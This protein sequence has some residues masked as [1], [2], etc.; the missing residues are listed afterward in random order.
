M[1][2]TAVICITRT[3]YTAFLRLPDRDEDMLHRWAFYDSMSE[4]GN[5]HRVPVLFEV[6]G[7]ARFFQS[8]C[9]DASCLPFQE[10]APGRDSFVERLTRYAFMSFYTSQRESPVE[11]PES[12]KPASLSPPL[13]NSSISH[14][15][16]QCQVSIWST[17]FATAIRHERVLQECFDCQDDMEE[18]L[19]ITH[20]VNHDDDGI[21]DAPA[22][23]VANFGPLLSEVTAYKPAKVTEALE[24]FRR[25]D[26]PLLPFL[27]P[28]LEFKSHVFGQWRGIEGHKNSCYFDVLAM[29]MF[30]FHDRFDEL[31]SN[32]RL[33]LAHSDDAILL[34]LLADLVVRP[35]RERIFV[36]RTAFAAIRQ[37]L[38]DVTEEA[39]YASGGIMEPCELLM[40]FDQLLPG[41]LKC[42]SSYQCDMK[43]YSD[44]VVSPVNYGLDANLTAQKLL[45]S[46][47]KDT[48]LVFDEAPKAFFLQM[49]PHISSEQR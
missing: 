19:I 10:D 45:S 32:E 4:I 16:P 48:G 44:L 40:H 12:S 11:S 30:A 15:C 31:F 22:S 42:I 37:H 25:Q 29:A 6:P 8:G 34:R 38:T 2:L 28:Q 47:C 23:Y 33:K 17:F 9:T 20:S 35:L 1:E 39:G 43:L 46:H 41:G 24:A 7:L 27:R 5:G 49:R 36:P 21:C 26:G 14:Q 18:H 13:S 3:H